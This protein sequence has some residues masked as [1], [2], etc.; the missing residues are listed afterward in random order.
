M[1]DIKSLIT[2]EN[3]KGSAQAERGLLAVISNAMIISFV[4]LASNNQNI[5]VDLDGTSSGIS[6]EF[7]GIP[8]NSQNASELT[9]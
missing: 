3:G 1:S 4:D 5:S 2:D 9:F 8:E 7:T 6:L